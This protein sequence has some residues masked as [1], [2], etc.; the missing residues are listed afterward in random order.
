MFDIIKS[1]L[2]ANKDLID[3]EL[4]LIYDFNDD[5]YQELINAQ[6]Y[7]LLGNGKRIRA[8]L[9]VEFCRLFS[10]DISKAI[11]Y[12]CAIEMIHASSLIHDDLPCMDND[13]FRRG[14]PSCH[15][16]YGESLALLAGD[17]LM[18]KAFEIISQANKTSE[19]SKILSYATSS[20]LAG[21]TMDIYAASHL[22]TI[23]K[24][25]KL[26]QRK[27]CALISAASQLGC[28]SA[29]IDNSDER[30]IAA[31]QYAENI[32]LAFQ[33]IDDIL[34]YKEGKKELNSF[35]SVTSLEEAQA[36][37]NDLTTKGIEAIS[38]Y[39]NG[40]FTE[41]ALYLTNREF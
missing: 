11:P 5:D 39:D 40:T 20:M 18:I 2:K 35:L 9:T 25:T 28:I 19:A 13:D 8:F 21:Q 36:Y 30:Y 37:A 29:D 27:T 17:A 33:I 15:K 7:S 1:R 3:K 10:N 16:K 38:P 6:K 24:L 26:H 14:K 4:S 41:L 12:A 34:D 23:D 31:V 32:G 22:I